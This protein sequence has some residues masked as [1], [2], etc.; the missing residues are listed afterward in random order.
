L[1]SDLA[2]TAG[3]GVIGPVLSPNQ[4]S[5]ALDRLR[6]AWNQLRNDVLGRGLA[7]PAHVPPALAEHVGVRYEAW[8]AWY[9]EWQDKPWDVI[10]M[11]LG[12]PFAR[13]LADWTEEYGHLRDEV[14]EAFALAGKTTSA[15]P[16]A[17][18]GTADLLSWVPAVA[19]VAG[20]GLFLLGLV[21]VLRATR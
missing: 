14:T 6:D 20:T 12:S 10:D 21:Y 4:A 15:P 11:H 9:A 3:S 19:A 13:G 17:P 7:P 8:R 5:Y 1:P 18:I 2:P 16:L